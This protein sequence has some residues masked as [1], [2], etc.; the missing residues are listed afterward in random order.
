MKGADE[1]DSQ[2]QLRAA[3][4][5]ACLSAWR[6]GDAVVIGSPENRVVCEPAS[7]FCLN[8]DSSALKRPAQNKTH[9]LFN[10]NLKKAEHTLSLF[11]GQPAVI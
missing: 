9:P 6:V 7:S 10:I 8:S 11:Y 5:W 3:R 1:S 4:T 2:A